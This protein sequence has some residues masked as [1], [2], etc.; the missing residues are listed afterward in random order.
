MGKPKNGVWTVNLNLFEKW[1][2]V[3]QNVFT[4][5]SHG[6]PFFTDSG[7]SRKTVREVC[8]NWLLKLKVDKASKVGPLVLRN[9]T[10]TTCDTWHWTPRLSGKTP[11]LPSTPGF[12]KANR[13]QEVANGHPQGIPEAELNPLEP[14]Q[15]LLLQG[16]ATSTSASQEHLLNEW[17]N[18]WVG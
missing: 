7:P 15:T 1:I 17:V 3:I 18:E 6:I 2:S 5:P 14:G 10:E 11:A 8:R 4:F 16:R 13:K 9:R 12:P